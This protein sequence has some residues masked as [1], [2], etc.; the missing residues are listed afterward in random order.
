MVENL[1]RPSSAVPRPSS[2]VE[3]PSRSAMSCMSPGGIKS[4]KKK[5][6]MLGQLQ[7]NKN[8]YGKDLEGMNFSGAIMTG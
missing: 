3:T 4:V 6:L 1:S 7:T 2:A 5:N 8:L